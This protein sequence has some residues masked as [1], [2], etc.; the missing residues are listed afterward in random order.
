MENE[1][2]KSIG[3]IQ[4]DNEV[5]PAIKANGVGGDDRQAEQILGSCSVSNDR[6]AKSSRPR[7]SS[8]IYGSTAHCPAIGDV[9]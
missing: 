2:K 7:V 1:A 9:R 6:Y 5:K 3:S 8:A 4:L